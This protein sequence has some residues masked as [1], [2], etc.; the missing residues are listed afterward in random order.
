MFHPLSIA[1]SHA[2]TQTHQ[3]REAPQPFRPPDR[4][5]NEEARRRGPQEPDVARA[6]YRAVVG[7]ALTMRVFPIFSE[8]DADLRAIWWTRNWMGYAIRHMKIDGKWKTMPAH[9]LVMTRIERRTLGRFELV[10]HKFGI[11]LDC[12]RSEIRLTTPRG[13]M[14]HL[15]NP[16]P[17]RGTW[18]TPEGSWRATVGWNHGHIHLAGSW[19]TRKQAA[20]AARAKRIELGFL[21]ELDKKSA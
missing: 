4:R 17:F 13:N 16:S 7:Y 19:P 1:A 20:A 12:R 2:T 11:L 8:E 5:G 21:G 15:T 10:D 9:R 14:Q 18:R 3:G 6:F